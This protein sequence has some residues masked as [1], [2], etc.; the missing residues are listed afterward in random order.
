MAR[1]I[2]LAVLLPA[3]EAGA[4]RR[5]PRGRGLDLAG[6]RD[7]ESLEASADFTGASSIIESFSGRDLASGVILTPQ[8]QQQRNIQAAITVV[9]YSLGPILRYGSA[10]AATK[11][12]PAIVSTA[13]G[14]GARVRAVA[15]AP[16]AAARSAT[17]SQVATRSTP[18]AIRLAP[19]AP[20]AGPVAA[21]RPAIVVGEGMD[22]VSAYAAEL[23]AQGINARTYRAPNMNRAVNP[24][25][26]GSPKSLDANR[27]WLDYWARGKGADVHSIGFQPGRTTP[28]VYFQMESRNLIRWENAG[29]IRPVIQV[30][31]G[32]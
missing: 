22:R 30:S 31:P 11:A 12:S 8:Q 15:A 28:S 10:V 5:V 26:Y 9:A 21:K 18:T 24:N 19:R 29:E 25:A 2:A 23:R 20:T 16:M 13:A 7:H 17:T 27:H 14:G 3:I 1:L 32:Y 4:T 6:V